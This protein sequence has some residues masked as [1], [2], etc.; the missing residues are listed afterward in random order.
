MAKLRLVPAPVFRFLSLVLSVLLGGALGT[1]FL[2]FTFSRVDS[3][4]QRSR[5]ILE[6][7]RTTSSERPEIVILGNSVAMNGIDGRRLSAALSGHP[8]VWNLSS[9]GQT[10]AEMLFILDELPESVRSVIVSV[11]PSTVIQS[12]MEVP[13]NKM[14]AYFMYGFRPTEETRQVLVENLIGRESEIVNMPQWRRAVES[15]W[16]TRAW[17]DT[18]VRGLLREDLQ[19]DRANTDLY[20]PRSYSGSL[21]RATRQRMLRLHVARDVGQGNLSPNVGAVLERIL[22]NQS[23]LGRDALLLVLPEHPHQRSITEPGF[24]DFLDRDLKSLAQREAADYLDLRS[25]LPE[26]N[27]YDHIHTDELGAEILTDALSDFLRRQK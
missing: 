5:M 2:A 24:Y 9:V 7:L 25:L 17:I 3:D 8:V 18:F 13:R 10:P 1:L 19:L 22:E 26:T 23:R 6:S 4:L 11:L 14:V 15:R 21:P 12:P 27:F 20:F 16:M